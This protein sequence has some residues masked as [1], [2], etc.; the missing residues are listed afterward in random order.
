MLYFITLTDAFCPLP[1]VT[2]H[3]LI[4]VF[5][6]LYFCFNSLLY[7]FLNFFGNL[8]VDL[9]AIFENA[10]EPTFCNLLDRIT[11]FLSLLQ[12]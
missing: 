7:F 9:L 1:T 11:T 4:L 3:Y 5:L 2:V 8:I 12:L 6:I 10:F